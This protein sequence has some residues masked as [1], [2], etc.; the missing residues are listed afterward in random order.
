MNEKTEIK[1]F[2]RSVFGG[3]LIINFV[4]ISCNNE[5]SDD[6][7]DYVWHSFGLEGIPVYHWAASQN[8]LFV[9]AAARGLWRIN[10]NDNEAEWTNLGFT[11]YNGSTSYRSGVQD[12]LIDD[13]NSDNLLVTTRYFDTDSSDNFVFRS[14]DNGNTWEPADSG[15]INIS[16]GIVRKKRIYLLEQFQD[17]IMGTGYHDGFY[18]T[19][20]FGSYWEKLDTTVAIDGWVL[21]K[22]PINENIV[23]YGGQDAAWTTK[24]YFS[25][26]SGMDWEELRPYPVLG[27][28]SKVDFIAL[29]KDNQNTVVVH[30]YSELVKSMDMGSTWDTLSLRVLL[31]LEQNESDNEIYYASVKDTLFSS[32]NG[33]Y[34]WEVIESPNEESIKSLFFDSVRNRL[35]L[36]SEEGVF[37]YG[38]D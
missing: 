36:S 5:K 3:V 34:T 31:N 28:D 13:N 30:T 11:I 22:H 19:T 8:Y 10:L 25:E 26:N 15:L 4:F 37:Y 6:E 1:R 14:F 12:I 33:G 17:F 2:L 20:D 35:Y 24:L 7:I 16:S 18:K 38:S 21:E 23:W 27:G 32:V 29:D 9:S